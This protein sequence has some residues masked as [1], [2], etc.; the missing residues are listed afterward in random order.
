MQ[1]AEGRGLG[2][3]SVQRGTGRDR[4]AEGGTQE[5]RLD[6]A[7]DDS[8]SRGLAADRAQGFEA[9]ACS[10]T[11]VVS[12]PQ[13]AKRRH[14]MAKAGTA[15]DSFRRPISAASAEQLRCPG[16]DKAAIK[17]S[18]D[19]ASGTGRSGIGGSERNT[20]D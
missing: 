14:S 12:L 17:A 6:D 11:R 4:D 2:H 15:C 20:A 13:P 8:C 3:G 1:E 16:S 9:A 7:V 19:S 5:D 18:S 10:R